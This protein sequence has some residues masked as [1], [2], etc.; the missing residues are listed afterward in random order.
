MSN[1][2]QQSASIPSQRQPQPIKFNGAIDDFSI[3]YI[4]GNGKTVRFLDD[5]Q[6]H[7][8]EVG[9]EVF[10]NWLREELEGQ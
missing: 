4:A 2:E 1:T 7:I 3:A 9:R 10:I 8:G 6:H 5:H